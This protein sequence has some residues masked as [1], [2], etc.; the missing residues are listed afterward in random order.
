MHRCVPTL[1]LDDVQESDACYASSWPLAQVASTLTPPWAR[2]VD[3][4]AATAG[5]QSGGGSCRRGV[6]WHG[7]AWRGVA[8]AHAA[9]APRR[10]VGWRAPPPPV[11]WCCVVPAWYSR[12]WTGVA[13]PWC[14]RRWRQ[15]GA[16]ACNVVRSAA[17]R[18]GGCG[19]GGS[20]S[21]GRERTLRHGRHGRGA[22]GC[23]ARVEVGGAAEPPP[24]GAA[25]GWRPAGSGGMGGGGV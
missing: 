15:Q 6:A 2:R 14:C 12:D 16:T 1:L 25:V 20:G 3:R 7:V 5:R 9:V 13:P 11:A 19:V 22:G 8:R 4:E 23:G 10:D 17:V 18:C 24:D 21:W